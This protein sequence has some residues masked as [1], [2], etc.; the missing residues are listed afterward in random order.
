VNNF[1]PDQVRFGKYTDGV[2]GSSCTGLAIF[3]VCALRSVGF[4]ARAAGAPHW[5]KGPQVCPHGDASPPCGNHNWAEVWIEGGWH[6]ISPA[7]EGCGS[8][9]RPRSIS[10][11]EGEKAA[12]NLPAFLDHGWFYPQP[13][14][15]QTPQSGNHS[16][17]ATSWAP[18]KELFFL[19]NGTTAEEH[20]DLVTDHFVMA[21]AQPGRADLFNDHSVNGWD[22]TPRYLVKPALSM[23]KHEPTREK[24]EEDEAIFEEIFS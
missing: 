23:E 3:L 22:V 10:G 8:G 11:G 24:S 4:P 9:E 17:Y 14:G 19:R 18:S 1:D 16:I 20:G 5:N 13:A 15:V 6:F 7:N 2:P 21:F 12:E